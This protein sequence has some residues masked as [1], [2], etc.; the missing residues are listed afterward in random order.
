MAEK[1]TIDH[2]TLRALAV[3]TRLSILKLLSSKDHTLTEISESLGL[4]AATVKE[5]LDVMHK[6]DLVKKEDTSRKWKY[7]SL[8]GKGKEI[9]MPGEK[10]IFF[11]FGL[12]VF[13][14]ITFNMMMINFLYG[15]LF[16][17]MLMGAGGQ[18]ISLL[19]K[20]GALT[21][22]YPWFISLFLILQMTIIISVYLLGR[23]AKKPIMIIK[24]G[25]K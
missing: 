1:I 3:D 24:G 20:I 18:S 11:V 19:E 2:D 16:P 7:Y 4:K 5:H 15:K 9:I 14:V 23:S 8:T 10:K 13:I 17:P 21:A 25:E 12:T 6:A 22:G